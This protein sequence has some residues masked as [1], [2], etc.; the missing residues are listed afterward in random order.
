MLKNYFK[1]A[2]RN[3]T[4]NQVF[5]AINIMGL[6]IGIAASLLIF[7]YVAFE[8]SYENTQTKADRI[9]RVQQDRYNDGKLSTQW[10]AGAFAAGNKFKEAF[11]EVEAYV[12]LTKRDPSLLETAG[13]SVKVTE[14]YYASSAY[15]EV[16]STPLIQGDVR[17][18][19]VEP[20]TV[21][22]SETLAHKLFG[23][24]D[25]V[26]KTLTMNQVRAFKVTGVYKDMPANTHL[27]AAALYS[28]ATFVDIVK[29]NNPEDA[30]QWDG[31]LTY[32][33]LRPGTNAQ[34]LEAKFPALVAAA[35]KDVQD[36][37]KAVYTLKSLKDIHL[38]SHQMMEAETNGNGS[39]VYL[40]MGIALFIVAIAWINYINLATARAINRAVE[41][42]V[43]KA[44]GSQ[45]SQLI[46]QFMV[47][48][49]LLNAMAVLLAL[50]LVVFAIP[51]FNSLTGQHLSFSLLRDSLFWSV[52]AILF[53]TGSF[54][55]GLY[56]A[57][58]LS[59]FKP[60]AVL[61]GKVISS[62]QGSTL[63]KSL[64]VVQF[65]ASLFLLVGVLAVFRQIQ[66]MRSQQLGISIDQTLVLNP[67]IVSRDST[68]LRK[69]EAFKKQLLQE[70]AV[71]SVT[72]S[73]VVP[74]E[75]CSWNAGAIRLKGADEKQGKQYRIIGVDYDYVPAYSLKLLA[76]R[77]FSPDFGMDGN[78][79][80]V[81]FNKTAVKQLGFDRPEEAV[82]KV[83]FFWG[84]YMR[85]EGVV[86]DFHQQSLHE[87]YEPLILRLIPDVQGYVSIRM[88][89]DNANATIAAV[90][91]SW[92]TVFP[93]NPFDYFFLDQHFDEQYRTDQRFGK[94][95]GIFTALAILVACLGLFGL[96]S[97]TIVQRTKEISI[98]KIL[99]ASVAEIVRLLYREFAVLI[100][101]AFFVATPLAWFSI[102]QWLKGYAFR[103]TL[104][105]WLFALPLALVLVIAFL[106]V[107]FQSIRAALANPVDSLRSE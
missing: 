50:F 66:F 58:V 52:L 24:E 14:H 81:I 20:N 9:Y 44:V 3:I 97:F 17:T 94:V 79:G 91:R 13:K 98:R 5:S 86:D 36:G 47:E 99:G 80:A 75:P 11:E 103:T 4:R 1:I 45:R 56:P 101:I 77:N 39:T 16:F 70:T 85:I 87:A 96:A 74:G 95:F 100:V 38:Y 15:F 71:R 51:L 69:Q 84:N 42:G 6:A 73:T 92:N 82:G 76:G 33:L 83:I 61:K 88:S 49:L 27:K 55:S 65:A 30:W 107:S 67:P 54:L 102:T 68:F 41:V 10:A 40:L 89:P 12:K 28:F 57:F 29:P 53:L 2:W 34:Q 23:N 48:S 35:S 31:C 21:V 25:P 60:V 7:Q 59:G 32:L 72:V 106:T 93:S 37:S 46:A 22:L 104:Y 90:Q 26:G 64:V 18:A 62:R 105:W 19:L 8:L 43:R 78:D 63:R